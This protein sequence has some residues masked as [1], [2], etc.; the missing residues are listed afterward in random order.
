MEEI[1]AKI[2]EFLTQTERTPLGTESD[3]RMMVKG[4]KQ[5]VV[6]D[7]VFVKPPE[8]LMREIRTAQ[9]NLN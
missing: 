2:E 9:Q 6:A 3:R 8:T 4:E 7:D 1:E 5:Q